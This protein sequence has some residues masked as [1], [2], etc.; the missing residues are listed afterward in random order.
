MNFKPS[1]SSMPAVLTLGKVL[2]MVLYRHM[3]EF[4]WFQHFLI[5]FAWWAYG[6]DFSLLH[7]ELLSKHEEDIILLHIKIGKTCF[8][9]IHEG[10]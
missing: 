4:L 9:L 5:S 7:V 1:N 3:I 8:S 6:E 2:E 10:G